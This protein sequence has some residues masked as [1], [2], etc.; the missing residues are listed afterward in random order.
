MSLKNVLKHRPELKHNVDYNNTVE[1]KS[2]CAIRLK[3][4]RA[5]GSSSN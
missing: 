1:K 4:A 5:E 3:K 2:H